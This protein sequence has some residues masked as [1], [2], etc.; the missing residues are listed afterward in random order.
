[1]LSVEIVSSCDMEFMASTQ[2][3]GAAG[4]WV[5][6]GSPALN[7]QPWHVLHLPLP[8]VH[9]ILILIQGF[10]PRLEPGARHSLMAWEVIRRANPPP[11][12][13]VTFTDPTWSYSCSV[14]AVLFRL[15]SSDLKMLPLLW[16]AQQ[17]IP[18][19]HFSPI[20]YTGRGEPWAL[21][22]RWWVEAQRAQ[23]EGNLQ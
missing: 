18:H 11:G 7:E 23:K 8:M 10:V 22:A 14:M 16:S 3:A 13:G 4:S 17:R 15:I 12:R 5:C 6:S 20:T 2:G 21:S 19:L 9:H 1:M